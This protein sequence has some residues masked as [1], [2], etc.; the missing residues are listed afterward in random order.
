MG[1]FRGDA[2]FEE[3]TLPAGI[4]HRGTGMGVAFG[5]VDGNGHPD[6]F[7]SGMASN[8]A[9]MI[10]LPRFPAP[11]PWPF[12][13]LLRGRILSMMK[14][15][16]HGNRFYLN[17]GDGSFAEVSAESGTRNSGWAFGGLF[18]DY[19]NDGQ[20]DIYVL[21]GLLSGEDEDDL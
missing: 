12:S 21:D 2:T 15:M 13:V 4:R 5:D 14:E 17:R 18:L 8:S 10:D 3:V 20:L 1:C 19:D 7:V 11:A 9:W 6:V 16:L